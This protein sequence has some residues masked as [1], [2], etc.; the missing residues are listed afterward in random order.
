[1]S[2]ILTILGARPQFVKAAVVSKAL[3]KAG[4]REE[5]I[6]T[7]Q[8][9]DARMSAVF[10]EELGIPAPAKNLEAGSGLHAR[11]TA[12]MLEKIEEHLVSSATAPRFVMVYGDTNSTLAG[13]L[14]ASKLHIPVIH[15]EAGLRSFNREMPEE[16]NRVLTDHISSVLFCSSEN[17]K[18]QLAKEGI[19]KGV[20][21][22]GDVM[23][24][25]VLT[26]S[27]LY[28]GDIRAD[29][30]KDEG[31][32][33]PDRFLLFTLH[34][35]SNTDSADILRGILNGVAS[36]GLPVVWPVHPRVRKQLES[37]SVPENIIC[38]SPVSYIMML[39]LLKSCEGVLTDSGGLQKE[40]YWLQKPCITLRDETEWTE[41]LE[42]GWN[43]LAGTD[44]GKIHHALSA[45][46][47]GTWKPL[48]GDGN[49]SGFIADHI[50]KLL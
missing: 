34:R 14:A 31:I 28:S 3:K 45:S 11:Q 20:H 23:Y 5:I 10:F 42:G 37:I 21:V 32:T 44:P 19:T 2:D 30:L 48:Y 33:L 18:M 6:H 1:M 22:S 50:T 26:F 15:I 49:A 4:I 25:A 13:A 41:T 43:R 39:Q 46:P 35:P 12:A 47:S 40:A 16:I 8:H 9:Y 27:K 17:G 7:G 36:A 38:I 29:I 24:D